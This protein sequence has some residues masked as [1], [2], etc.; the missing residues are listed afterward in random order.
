MN[1]Q[2]AEYRKLIDKCAEKREDFTIPNRA[3]EHAS[4]LIKTLFKIPDGKI[5]RIFTGRLHEDVFADPELKEEAA[6]FLKSKNDNKIEIAYQD[7][8]V[9]GQD[10]LDGNFLQYLL[11]A[12]DTKNKIEVWDASKIPAPV[13]NHFAVIDEE[14]FRFEIDEN[15]RKAIGNFGDKDSA[16]KLAIIFEK[17]IGQSKKIYPKI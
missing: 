2:E 12:E 5:M 9:A 8:T 7:T 1:K 15:T 6:N 4:Y 14:A 13:N 17:I 16:A 3:P 10:I 11:G